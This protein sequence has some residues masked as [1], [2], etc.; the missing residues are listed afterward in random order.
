M[1]LKEQPAWSA[2]PIT[3]LTVR[4]RETFQSRLRERQR[5]ALGN[6]TLLD[7]F[8]PPRCRLCQGPFARPERQYE[9]EYADASLCQS[10]KLAAVGRLTSSIAHETN[11]P[12]EVVTN[13]LYLLDATTLNE[14]QRGYLDT[15]RQELAR[16]S[17][18][19]AQTLTFNRERDI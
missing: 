13:L 3:V 2:L 14:V 17:E 6:T 9:L 15:A 4:G 5:L 1:A 8:A 12:L 19:A 10:D 7:R 11:N 18:I 16:V